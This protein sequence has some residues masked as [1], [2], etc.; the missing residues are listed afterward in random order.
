MA[1]KIIHVTDSNIEYV[2]TATGMS[3]DQVEK[4]FK[5]AQDEGVECT[6]EVHDVYRGDK[7]P[8]DD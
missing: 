4:A 5:H 6:L 8:F 1:N 3:I 2:A 7:E